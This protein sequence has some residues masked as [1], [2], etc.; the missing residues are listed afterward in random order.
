M[1]DGIDWAA[2][3]LMVERFGIEDVDVFVTQ[4]VAIRL[5]NDRKAA[6]DRAR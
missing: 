4:L 2:I 6:A 1:M 3:P 5:H